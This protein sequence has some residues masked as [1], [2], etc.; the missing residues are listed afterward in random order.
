MDP[1]ATLQNNMQRDNI[2]RE[3]TGLAELLLA[4]N[5]ERVRE[6]IQALNDRVQGVA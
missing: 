1:F 4:G 6:S 3:L 2:T 5:E